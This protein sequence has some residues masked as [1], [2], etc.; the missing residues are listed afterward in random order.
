LK[1]RADSH[2]HKANGLGHQALDG[3][4]THELAEGRGIPLYLLPYLHQFL[5][6]L[7]TKLRDVPFNPGQP[8]T[9]LAQSKVKDANGFSNGHVVWEWPL[10]DDALGGECA[11]PAQ[12]RRALNRL[13]E[14]SSEHPSKRRGQ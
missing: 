9:R 13:P 14:G 2:H 11:T 7:A 3:R 6:S 8:V 10:G 5:A 12:C 4:A 1:D